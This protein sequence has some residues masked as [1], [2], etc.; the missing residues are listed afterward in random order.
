MII[1][2]VGLNH[3]GSIDRA[4][5]YV[6]KLITTDVDGITFQIREDEFYQG[7]DMYRLSLRNQDYKKLAMLIKSANKQFG[8]A[9]ANIH[10]IKFL[11]SIDTDFYKVIRNDIT[12]IELLET[13]VATKKK[14]IVSTGM[15]SDADIKYFVNQF[16]NDNVVLNHTQLSHDISD[17]NL[18]AIPVLQKKY[19]LNISFGSHCKNI[20]VLYMALTYNPSDILFYVKQESKG[21]GKVLDDEHAIELNKIDSVVKNLKL[22]SNAIGNGN[23]VKTKNKIEI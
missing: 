12:N 9:I 22:L 14:I 1:A 15:S 20:N 2:E 6:E 23:K 16:G 21:W 17:C 11:E 4:I 5:Q 18:S 13:L 7:T 10:K 3:L 8:V 19:G